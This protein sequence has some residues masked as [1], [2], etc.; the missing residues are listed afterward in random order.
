MLFTQYLVKGMKGAADTDKD[1]IVTAK[2]IFT[3]VS[4]HVSERTHK[5]Q[6]PVNLGKFNG[7][8]HIFNWN[9]KK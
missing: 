5:K 1:R 7:D 3:Y 2:E 9:P 4:K 8:M 6:N